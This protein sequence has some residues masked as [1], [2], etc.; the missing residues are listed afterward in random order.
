MRRFLLLT[1]VMISLKAISQDS[2]INDLTKDMDG[3][4]NEKKVPAKIFDSQKAIN[5]NTTE[6]VGKGKMEFR[7]M[8]NFYDVAGTNGGIE[9]FFGLD[10]AADIKIA[11]QVGLGHRFDVVGARI[12]GGEPYQTPYTRVQKIYE[13]G[14]KYKFLEQLENDPKH[15]L[16]MALFANIAVTSMPIPPQVLSAPPAVQDSAINH[17][18]NFSERLSQTLQLIIAR[19]FGK[20]SLQVSGTLVHTN[21]VTTGDDNSILALG[22]VARVPISK[23]VAIII[24]YMHPFHSEDAKNFFKSPGSVVH[25]V[26]NFYDLLGVGFEITTAGH[27]FHLNFTNSTELLENRYIPRTVTSWS[28]GQFRWSFSIARKFSLWRPKS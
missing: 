19:K 17:Y 3:S 25:P 21:R 24:D 5:A 2:T 22:A 6:T 7:V 23:R 26:T 1:M 14:F 28:K 13:L 20:V 9:N 15:P 27:V 8:H 4:A 16:S 11:F 10:N 12:R 18:E